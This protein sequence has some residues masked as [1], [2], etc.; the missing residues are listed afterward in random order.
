ML[1]FT[2]DSWKETD[3]RLEILEQNPKYFQEKPAEP[4]PT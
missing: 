3:L 4:S 2:T 1:V